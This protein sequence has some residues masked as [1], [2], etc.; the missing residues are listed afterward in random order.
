MIKTDKSDYQGRPSESVPLRIFRKID[1]FLNNPADA[2]SVVASVAAS[3]SEDV[4]RHV[5]AVERRNSYRDG[6]LIQLAFGLEHGDG[7]D[8]IHRAEGARTAA[9]QLG[10]G[11]G[12][13]HIPAVKDAYQNIGKNSTNLAR[14][15]LAA[16]DALLLWRNKADKGQRE[17]LLNYVAAV[18]A[19]SARPVLKMPNL[20]IA[21]L[22]FAALAGFLDELLKTPSGGAFEQFSVAAFIDSLLYEFGLGGTIGGLRVATK[23]INASDTSTGAAADIQIMR[24]NKIEEA[25]EVSANNWRGKISQAKNATKNADLS[26]VHIIAS[27][28]NDDADLTDLE[29]AETDISVLDIQSFLRVLIAALRKPSREYALKRLYELIDRNQPNTELTNKFVELLSNRNLTTN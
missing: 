29:N 27:T 23:N 16:F 9:A 1:A 4:I 11:F 21:S 7:F 12:E 14:G 2:E 15:N 3:L 26:R 22:T 19:L 8:H 13:R 24:A 10:L 25:F 17:A 28:L 6:I 20:R 5:K 18:V